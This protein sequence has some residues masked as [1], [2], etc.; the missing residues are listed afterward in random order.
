MQYLVLVQPHSKSSGARV[1]TVTKIYSRRIIAIRVTVPAS[2][3]ELLEWGC[4]V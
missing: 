3:P 4:A 2:V 1:G